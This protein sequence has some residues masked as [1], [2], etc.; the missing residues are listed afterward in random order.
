MLPHQLKQEVATYEA[1]LA[2]TRKELEERISSHEEKGKSTN[3]ELDDAQKKFREA[4]SAHDTKIAELT[5]IQTQEM[6][7]LRSVMKCSQQDNESLKLKLAQIEKDMVEN[8]VTAD[9]ASQQQRDELSSAQNKYREAVA[10]QDI[11]YETQTRGHAEQ[12]EELRRQILSTNLEADKLRA[13]LASLQ[14]MDATP[15]EAA[16][17]V[18]RTMR[19]SLALPTIEEKVKSSGHTYTFLKYA[20]FGAVIFL[21]ICY[22]LQLLSMNALCSPVLPGTRLGKD[23]SQIAPWWAPTG[24]KSTA[25]ELACHSC[26]Q[27][28]LNWHAGRLT[29]SDKY[30][31]ILLDRKAPSAVV[32]GNI[33]NFVDKRGKVETLKTP[34]SS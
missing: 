2:A 10:A 17:I 23:M 18:E 30:G 28:S 5:K 12:T 33:I 26:L 34:W 4:A 9:K 27:T 21:T 25:F 6:D 15:E 29:I 32:Y 14:M 19:S 16:K 1:K 31:K 11:R 8:S 20:G 13:Q 24:S 22:Q 7:N 3:I